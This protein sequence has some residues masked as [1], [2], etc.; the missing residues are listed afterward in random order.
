M[1]E[2]LAWL[3]ERNIPIIGSPQLARYNLTW[4]LP[5]LGRN[6][7]MI[8]FARW[9]CPGGRLFAGWL[10]ATDGQVFHAPPTDVVYSVDDLVGPDQHLEQHAVW[11]L[12]EI[13]QISVMLHVRA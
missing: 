10:S 5:M 13:V 3:E 11:V 8:E 12:R 6:E 9:A 7:V 4:T 1:D 2:L